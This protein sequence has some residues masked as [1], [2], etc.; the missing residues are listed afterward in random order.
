[1]CKKLIYLI[2]FTLV[3][4]LAQGQA[5]GAYRAAYWDGD[6][7][8]G[9]SGGGAGTRDALEAKGYEI[10]SAAALKTWMDARIADG[11][12]SVVVFCQDA[13]PDTVAES[14]SATCTL[15]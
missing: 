12:A 5:R 10:L 13:V 11:A 7:D 4:G 2:F 1:M 8:Y 9:W 15:R 14:M 3:L 6:R